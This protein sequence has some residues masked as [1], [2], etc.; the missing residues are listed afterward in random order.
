MLINIASL[1]GAQ[2]QEWGVVWQPPN[3]TL[4]AFQQWQRLRRLGAGALRLEATSIPAFLLEV[5]D[6]LEIALFVDLPIVNAPAR[7]LQQRLP[8]AQKMLHLLL[9]QIAGHAS[10]RAVGLARLVDTADPKTCAYFEALR[11]EVRRTQPELQ[12]YYE[13]RFIEKDRCGYAVDFVLL[14]VRG[15]EDPLQWLRRWQ[16]AHPTVPVGLGRLGTW[17]RADTLRGLR[18]PHSPEWQARYLERHLERLRGSFNGLVFVYRWQDVARSHPA[19]HLDQPFVEAY[20]LHDLQGMPRPAWEVVRGFFTGTQTVFAFPAGHAPAAPWPWAVLV[21]W[22][23]I[24]LL[25]LSYRFSPLFRLLGI[26]Y[27]RAHGFYTEAVQYG[28]DLP[29]GALAMVGLAEAIALGVTLGAVAEMLQESPVACWLVGL[30]PSELTPSIVGV[31]QAPLGLLLVTLLGSLAM[32]GFWA[33][34]LVLLSRWGRRVGFVQAWTL[35]HMPRWWLFGLM[36]GALS[37]PPS[38]QAGH[39]LLALWLLMEGWGLGRTLGDAAQVVRGPGW[40]YPGLALLHASCW[41]LLVV[42]AGLGW[43]LYTGHTVM[44]GHL[45]S[46][47]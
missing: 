32:L 14:D 42:L 26:R 25:V 44:L 35:V 39:G 4:L 15:V 30:L 6:S 7:Q 5:A 17:V 34:G 47:R 38:P 16:Q 31:I 41:L 1:W 40:L 9:Q 46:V 43:G 10:A 24:V 12:V 45:L 29:A 27:F 18:V 2:A 8:E 13:T 11:A 19:L 23:P 33:L 20:G 22:I 28:R 21:G 36:V 3:D 37:L